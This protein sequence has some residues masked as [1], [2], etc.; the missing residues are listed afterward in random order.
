MQPL[1]TQTWVQIPAL[2]L[3]L[4]GPV[5]SPRRVVPARASKGGCGGYV[6]WRV[7]VLSALPGTEPVTASCDTSHSMSPDMSASSVPTNCP[8]PPQCARLRAR[9]SAPPH[10]VPPPPAPSAATAVAARPRL[11]AKRFRWGRRPHLTGRSCHL[12]F[13]RGRGRLRPRH[14]PG[15]HGTRERGDARQSDPKPM[16]R[17]AAGAAPST[18]VRRQA[19]C[20][21]LPSAAPSAPRGHGLC[22]GGSTVAGRDD[23]G[24]GGVTTGALSPGRCATELGTAPAGRVGRGHRGQGE[25][26]RGLRREVQGLGEA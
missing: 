17:M 21:L 19:L 25:R 4:C 24:L 15:P 5:T 23:G 7:D 14:L 9:L 6:R 26:G 12:R 1:G 8:R 22:E 16:R 2:L 20:G 10:L 18:P 13:A 3:T 11:D